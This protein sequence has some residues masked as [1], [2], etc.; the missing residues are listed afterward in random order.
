MSP[1]PASDPGVQ[2]AR[3]VAPGSPIAPLRGSALSK[4]ERTAR[5]P[6]PKGRHMI[7]RGNAPGGPDARGNAPGLKGAPMP[8]VAFLFPGQGSQAL[9]MGKQLC[10]TLPAAKQLF[11]DASA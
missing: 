7:A 11:D 10:A 1:R 9:G 6:A 8:K 2:P 5:D 4:A 3:G